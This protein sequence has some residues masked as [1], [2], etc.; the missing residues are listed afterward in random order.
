MMDHSRIL[1][2]MA[3]KAGRS[4]SQEELRELELLLTQF[5]EYGFL[6][7]VLH[8]L[9]GSRDHFE[10]NIPREELVDHGWQ[11]LSGKL[12]LASGQEQPVALHPPARVVRG[13]F[14]VPARWA[15]AA[16]LI[17]LLVGGAL[18]FRST[19]TR[20]I[21]N[22]ENKVAEVHYGKTSQLV[23][24]DGSRVWLNAGS[25]LVYPGHFSPLRREVSL[26]GEAFFEVTHNA[27][28]PFLVHAGKL[29]VR[30]LG[31]RFNVKAYKEDA[32]I[33]TTLISGK[34]QV[35]IN[36]DPD[37]KITLSPHEKLTVINPPKQESSRQYNPAA[38]NELKYQVQ[39]LPATTTN[40]FTETAWLENKLVLS[41]E[42]F[43]SVARL[44]ERKYNIHVYFENSRL[45]QERI[46]GVFEK[47][48]IRQVLR[49]L[50]MTTRFDYRL[51]GDNQVYL[52]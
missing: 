27:S 46:S 9:K 48:N 28:V 12:N 16:I 21:P 45:K 36:D 3:K 14:G 22:P 5:P 41:N 37:K 31:T 35:M 26:E 15:S 44:L 43:E 1:E 34:V 8:S 50:K 11:H 39:V 13:F 52:Y 29:T 30:V 33:E 19:Y 6:A 49:I 20:S 23:L 17:A 40:S 47:E 18:Y 32:D 24:P 2:L 7:E 38:I 4:A 25:R 42:D 10:R 51:E